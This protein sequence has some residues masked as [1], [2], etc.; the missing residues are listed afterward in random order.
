[1][2]SRITGGRVVENASSLAETLVERGL[3]IVS[4]GT[5]NHLI[6]LDVSGLGVTGADAENAL[7]AVDLTCN[8]NLIPYDEQPPMKASGV[9]IGSAAVT[10]RG[11]GKDEMVRMGHWIADVLGAPSDEAVARRVK[12][13][14]AEVARAFPIYP[15]A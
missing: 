6:L 4:G 8:K 14:V 11:L 9:R 2:G 15:E 12:G 7:H 1:M 13:E 5:D 3:R 10:T